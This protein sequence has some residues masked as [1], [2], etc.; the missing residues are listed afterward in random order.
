M[1]TVGVEEEYLLVDPVTGRLAPHAEK[2]RAAAGL[3]PFVISEELQQP[4]ILQAQVEVATPVC[5]TLEE[6]GGHL[7]RLRHA[8]ADAAAE[9]GYRIMA[10]GTSLLREDTPLPI[11][12]QARYKAMQR[13]AP[14]LV[15]EQMRSVEY[16]AQM[17]ILRTQ[18]HRCH[19]RV[20]KVQASPPVSRRRPVAKSGSTGV[21]GQGAG[22]L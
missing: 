9:N 10:S 16:P 5:D 13:Q 15:A 19:G 14:Q 18:R 4:E 6:I 21:A 20:M 1:A 17:S 11:T 22:V 3:R 7:L 2:I 12:E 8:V